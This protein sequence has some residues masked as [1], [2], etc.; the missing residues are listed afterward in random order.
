MTFVHSCGN[1]GLL[2]GGYM[3]DHRCDL[4]GVIEMG[5]PVLPGALC[6]PLRLDILPQLAEAW[7][8]VRPGARVVHIAKPPRKGVGTRPGRG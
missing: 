8:V 6:C 7:S 4:R 2:L 5:E 3:V 1:L